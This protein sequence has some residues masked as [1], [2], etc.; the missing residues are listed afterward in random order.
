MAHWEIHR[1]SANVEPNRREPTPISLPSLIDPRGAGLPWSS[2]QASFPDRVRR[3]R[4]ASSRR[5]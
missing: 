5:C 3:R 1:G 4:R 2:Q